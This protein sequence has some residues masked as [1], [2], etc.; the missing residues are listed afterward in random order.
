MR[1][2]EPHELSHWCLIWIYI[3]HF[4]HAR[5][6]SGT[7]FEALGRDRSLRRRSSRI[8]RLYVG[9]AFAHGNGLRQ[10][11]LHVASIL[12]LHDQPLQRGG[13]SEDADDES[14]DSSADLF[15]RS[16]LCSENF[17]I[18]FDIDRVDGFFFKGEGSGKEFDKTTYMKKEDLGP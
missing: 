10:Q 1:E 15:R 8:P 7:V 2:R 16:L 17:L 14:Y 18:R 11:A 12:Q 13:R 6:E 9:G 4:T 3:I 5:A